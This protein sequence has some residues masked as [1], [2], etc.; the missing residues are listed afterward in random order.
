MNALAS[1][2]ASATARPPGMPLRSTL[3]IYF[4]EIRDEFVKLLRI[5]AYTLMTILPP[6]LFYYITAASQQ[7]RTDNARYALAG[8]TAFGALSVGMFGVGVVLAMDRDRGLLA[9]KRAFPMPAGAY[10]TSKLVLSSVL[11]GIIALLSSLVAISVV[12]VPLPLPRLIA[13]IGVNV[14]GVLP[15]CA[16]GLYIGTLIKG[17]SSGAVLNAIYLPM[18]FL[19]GLWVPLSSVPHALAITAPLW[20]AYHL[21]QLNRAALADIPASNL[22]IH[23]AY[24][25]AMTIVLFALS[26]QRLRKR[27]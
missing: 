1:T 8:F 10:L 20:P 11:S 3:R 9:L 14:I 27:G 24:L 22:T 16:L 5:P 13:L 7:G 6:V 18:S 12:N 25:V 19:S 15:F 26:Y 23:L 21:A 17:A 4:G 2:V